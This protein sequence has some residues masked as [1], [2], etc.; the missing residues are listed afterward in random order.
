MAFWEKNISNQLTQSLTL[1]SY[2]LLVG[3]LLPK[4]I[5]GL[6][7]HYGRAVHTV[8]SKLR[9][10][11]IWGFILP[12][13]IVFKAGDLLHCTRK[14]SKAHPENTGSVSI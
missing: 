2:I 1:R 9:F 13:T 7:Q 6:N 12:K 14:T 8:I 11:A 4:K 10:R 5:E 3:E